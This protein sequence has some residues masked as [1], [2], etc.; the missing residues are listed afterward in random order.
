[1]LQIT[2]IRVERKEKTIKMND[3]NLVELQI[4]TEEVENVDELIREGG[5]GN[6]Q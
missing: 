4:P 2:G 1:M 3:K 6:E 5:G